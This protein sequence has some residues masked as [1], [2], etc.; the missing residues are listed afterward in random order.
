MLHRM[1]FN[2]ALVT[3][4]ST[5]TYRSHNDTVSATAVIYQ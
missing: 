5:P 1:L 4:M 2:F 3:L